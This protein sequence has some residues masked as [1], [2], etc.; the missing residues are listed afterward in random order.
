M[1]IYAKGSKSV[2]T[3]PSKD[4]LTCTVSGTMDFA[5]VSAWE[6]KQMRVNL[7]F[8]EGGY[9]PSHFSPNDLFSESFR[10]AKVHLITLQPGDCLYIPSYWWY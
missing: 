9:L 1:E 10:D 8:P 7:E 5:V 6:H 2:T 3:M 4:L